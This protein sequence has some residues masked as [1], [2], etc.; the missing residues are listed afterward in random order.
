MA[1]NMFSL[2]KLERVYVG[3]LEE[4]ARVLLDSLLEATRTACTAYS[5]KAKNSTESHFMKSWLKCTAGW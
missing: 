2:Q 3:L 1:D 4:L 5:I